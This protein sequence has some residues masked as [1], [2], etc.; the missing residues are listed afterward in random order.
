MERVGFVGAGRLGTALARALAAAGWPVVA[1]ASRTPAS[2]TRLARQLPGAHAVATAQEVAARADL[3]FLTVP[4]AAIAAVAEAVAWRPGQAV[5]HTSGA[6]ALAPLAAA[7]R[8]GALVGC[9]HPLQTFAAPAADPLAPFAGVTCALDGD[10]ALLPRLEALVAALGARPLRVPP[11]ARA[12]YHASAALAA[13][14]LVTLLHLAASLWKTFG[15]DERTATAALLPLARAAVE[16]VATQGAGAA[17]TG[18][19]ARGDAGTVARHRAALA[20]TRPDLLPAYDALASA[21]VALARAHGH[22]SAEAATA[23]QRLLEGPPDLGPFVIDAASPVE[24][25]T[26]AASRP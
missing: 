24:P 6:D 25:G 21:T 12:L 3:V 8:Q 15:I 19:I 16:N 26:P 17:L 4:D 18:P 2:A 10:A 11:E 7:R 22:L 9:L 13:N 1:L 23:L 20:A 14:A 5:V